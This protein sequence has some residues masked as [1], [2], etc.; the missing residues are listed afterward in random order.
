[1][2][3]TNQ[4]TAIRECVVGQTGAGGDGGDATGTGINGS[5][6]NGG[7][8]VNIVSDATDTEVRLSTISNTGAGGAI[9]TGGSG[10]APVAGTDGRA[11]T[12]LNVATT[13]ATNASI[14][15]SNFAYAIANTSERYL[16]H[17]V[18]AEGGVEVGAAATTFD[19]VYVA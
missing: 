12:D 9:G 18:V 3:G 11:V 8:G 2:T 10:G 6:G 7:D 13:S 14:I 17:A 19:H 5:G 4:G 1:M 15:F 16:L